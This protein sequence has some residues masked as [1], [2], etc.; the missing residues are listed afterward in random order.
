MLCLLD[1]GISI[2][3]H[4]IL[5]SQVGIVGSSDV[6]L[7]KW[8]RVTDPDLLQNINFFIIIYKHQWNTRWAFHENM[9]SSH[10]REITISMAT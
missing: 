5:K 1:N 6:L 2:M 3:N 7:S 10:V 8:S 4:W 9:I